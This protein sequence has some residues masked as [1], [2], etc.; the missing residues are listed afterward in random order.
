MAQRE[1]AQGKKGEHEKKKKQDPDRFGALQDSFAASIGHFLELE[2]QLEREESQSAHLS[3]RRQVHALE[4]QTL[5]VAPLGRQEPKRL[6]AR[7]LKE[8]KKRD[9]QSKKAFTHYQAAI[10][11]LHACQSKKEAPQQYAACL[12]ILQELFLYELDHK[13]LQAKIHTIAD[14]CLRET[15]ERAIKTLAG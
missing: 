4:P 12:R 2:I 14:P 13:K 1:E 8:L 3:S 5:Q 7:D 6:F 15:L 10:E 9:H 11:E